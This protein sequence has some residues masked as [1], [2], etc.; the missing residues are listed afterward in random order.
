MQLI[1][2]RFIIK[3]FFS[4]MILGSP[5]VWSSDLEKIKKVENELSLKNIVFFDFDKNNINIIDKNIDF[6]ILNFWASW[7]AP[8]IKEMKSLNNLKK[9]VSNIKIITISQDSDIEDA[10][11]FFK[12]NRYENLEKYYD[13]EK[14]VSKNFSLRGLPTTFIFDRELKSFAKIEGIIE[15]DTKKFIKWLKS[16]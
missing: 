2:T 14:L 6:Y 12:K 10:I 9:K 5:A 11:S 3:I 8:C 15:W 4:I 16:N 7:C 1:S 13:Y